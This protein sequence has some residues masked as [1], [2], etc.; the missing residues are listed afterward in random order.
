MKKNNLVLASF[1]MLTFSIISK[2]S[3]FLRELVFAYYY[4]A[5]NLTDAY[6]TATTISVT[7][8]S[9]IT[10]AVTTGYIPIISV[11][12]KEKISKITSNI[13][14]IV[15]AIIVTTSILGIIF[16]DQ[17]IPFFAV[18][19]S[20]ENRIMVASMA[21]IILPASFLYVIY[22]VLNG[23]LQFNHTFWTVGVAVVIN[24]FVNMIT[25]AVSKGNLKVL[26]YGYV[27]S[28]VL[29]AI[30]L[31]IISSRKGFK[32]SLEAKPNDEVIKRIVKMGIPIFIGQ[33]IF[34]FNTLIDRNFASFLGEGTITSMK[35]AYQL[36][37]FVITI[38]VISIV[39][40][41]YPS[42]SKLSAEE[43]F[44]EYKKISSVSMNT[45]LLFVLP[46]TVAFFILAGQIVELVFLR[47]EFNL[48]DAK[49]TTEVLMAYALG[50]P[51]ISLNE[52]LNKQFYSLRDT[53]TPVVSNA[54]SLTVNIVL[55]LI[56]VWKF[57]HIGLAFATAAA[58]TVLAGI[59]Y[60]RLQRKIGSL[61]TKKFIKNIGKMTFASVIMGLCVW[62]VV[63]AIN[64]YT[65]DLSSLG[66][67]IEIGAAAVVGAS[68]YFIMTYILKV[69]ELTVAINFIKTKI[70]KKKA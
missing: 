8:F 54:M 61:G 28:W 56:L 10:V 43:N 55:N 25:F 40:A 27:L 4:G 38:F 64:P 39:T 9:G 67:I 51:A 41:I 19:F 69:E 2:L 3:G 47:G 32:Y 66:N 5:S 53:K 70:N 22:N 44:D 29:P 17:I 58:N 16:I 12:A 42:L 34:Q 14:N 37:L 35:Y 23:F 49:I 7:I 31:F 57:E 52:V 26:A 62:F 20:E 63:L 46:I 21:S 24:N 18:G 11:Y 15:T 1:V 33:I 36:I 60:Y 30:F 45:I 13:I 6:I 65:N 68:V 48:D 50:L 59:L